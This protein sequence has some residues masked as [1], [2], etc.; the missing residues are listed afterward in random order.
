MK[1]NASYFL[2]QTTLFFYIYKDFS[3]PLYSSLLYQ[4]TLCI[5]P[6]MSSSN[7][8]LFSMVT[9][10]EEKWLWKHESQI[11]LNTTWLQD[12]YQLIDFL[13]HIHYASFYSKNLSKKNWEV[14]LWKMKLSESLK[15]KEMKWTLRKNL[16]NQNKSII[17]KV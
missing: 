11:S 4:V 5:V 16:S 1:W 13:S 6:I 9:C 17:R 3:S 8:S 7:L 2:F 14:F 10:W 12:N 15:N